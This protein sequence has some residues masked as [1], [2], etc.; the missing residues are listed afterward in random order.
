MKWAA[1]TVMAGALTLVGCR[2]GGVLRPIKLEVVEAVTQTWEP[3]VGPD[4]WTHETGL[5]LAVP[6]GWRGTAQED[7]FLEIEHPDA[8]VGVRIMGVSNF[9]VE[10]VS[11][12]MLRERRPCDRFSGMETCVTWTEREP[13]AKGRVREVWLLGHPGGALALEVVYP[14]GGVVAGTALADVLLEGLRFTQ[15]AR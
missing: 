6:D 11:W 10:A 9:E 7:P 5:A 14:F 2:G 4:D 1:G 12:E 3:V 8:N 13:G 15:S